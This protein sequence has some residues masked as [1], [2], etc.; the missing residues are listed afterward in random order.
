[1]NVGS[2]FFWEKKIQYIY[3]WIG[4]LWDAFGPNRWRKSVFMN[5]ETTPVTMNKNGRRFSDGT[6]STSTW[7]TRKHPPFTP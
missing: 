6:F 4:R 7:E 5:N 2:P 1:M 3:T